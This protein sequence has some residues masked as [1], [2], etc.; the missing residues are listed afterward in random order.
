[1]FTGIIETVGRLR[2]I[3]RTEEYLT[4][5]IAPNKPLEKIVLGESIAVDGCCL[6]VTRFERDG[7]E[8]EVSPESIRAT[9]IGGYKT[10]RLVNL[11]RAVRAEGRFGGHLV[12][13]HIDCAGEI[14]K[15]T[16]RGNGLQIAVR[17]PEKYRDLVV[18][19]GSIAIDGV[20]L[21]INRVR[22]NLFDVNII[23]HTRRETTADSWEEGVLV[24]LEF[25]LIGKYILQRLNNQNSAGV[26]MEMLVKSGWTP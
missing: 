14:V 22:E 5:A 18:E 17:F 12:S 9:I 25:D 7:F 23:P 4:M 16:P 6:T 19:K 3:G 26:T 20:S 15:V 13:G 10:G 8:A 2:R 21:T 1:M 11:E 24:N